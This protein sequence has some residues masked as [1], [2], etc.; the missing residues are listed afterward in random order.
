VSDFF[1]GMRRSRI[2]L[3][4]NT[5]LSLLAM[6]VSRRSI[7]FLHQAPKSGSLIWFAKR[8]CAFPIARTISAMSIA[9]NS[10]HGSSAT[11]S[12]YMFRP[13]TKASNIAGRWKTGELW[14]VL[15][16][17]SRDRGAVA[18]AVFS[19]VLD[20]VEKLVA[21]G[22]AVLAIVDDRKARAAIKLLTGSRHR[23]ARDR[24]LPGDAR[25]GLSREGSGDGL[26]RHQ[27]RLWRKSAACSRRG[28]GTYS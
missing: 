11:N 22:E 6:M 18:N 27:Y 3:P 15:L 12:A 9:A 28:P 5:P 16:K 20:G 21:D 19:R 8:R 17:G 14:E 24:E 2:L 26:A 7:G 23:S 13:R 1:E 10:V 4:D 25:R